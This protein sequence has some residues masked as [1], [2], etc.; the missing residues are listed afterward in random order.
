M[1]PNA[2]FAEAR[3]S[4][5]HLWQVHL[6]F[7]ASLST[8]ETLELERRTIFEPDFARELFEHLYCLSG[9]LTSCAR[10]D[11]AEFDA[12]DKPFLDD[13][14]VDDRL[15]ASLTRFVLVFEAHILIEWVRL[16]DCENMAQRARSRIDSMLA[17][18]SSELTSPT[19]H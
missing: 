17:S 11:D 10:Q 18:A 1:T 5:A 14:A 3:A 2:V 19:L 13:R 8:L 4:A 16:S 7:R 9:A 12:C 15:F 6:R